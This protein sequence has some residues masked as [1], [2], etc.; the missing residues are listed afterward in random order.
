[1]DKRHGYG[2]KS[3]MLLY[4]STSDSLTLGMVL[5][6]K[7]CKVGSCLCLLIYSQ[8]II[9]FI[10]HTSVAIVVVNMQCIQV[11]PALSANEESPANKDAVPHVH[12]YV[13]AA[14]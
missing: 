14:I 3:D 7:T 8:C 11:V 13:S 2:H 4:F 12:L 5:R 10:V 6:E 9:I 1:M